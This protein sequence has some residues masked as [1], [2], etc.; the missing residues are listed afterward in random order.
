MADSKEQNGRPSI[1]KL[2]S[3]ILLWLLLSPYPPLSFNLSYI[4]FIFFTPPPPSHAIYIIHINF[5]HFPT[6]FTY[7]ALFIILLIIFKCIVIVIN[8]FHY[9][10]KQKTL[11]KEVDFW[12]Q[13]MTLNSPMN[14]DTEI[15]H[16]EQTNFT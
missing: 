6:P 2:F 14:T 1:R 13:V 16:C 9:S 11:D 7:Q 3:I 12:T 5:P 15:M 10:D 8:N 4:L